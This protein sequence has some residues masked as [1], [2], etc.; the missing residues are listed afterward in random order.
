MTT[1]EELN[2]NKKTARIA[3][4][5]YLIVAVFG[6]FAIIFVLDKVYSPGDAATT[7]ANVLAN[8]SLVR[9]GVV[10]DLIQATVFVFLGMLL[11]QLLKHVNKNAARSMV[12]L[13]AIATTIMC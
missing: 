9:I 2:S 12:I 5:L 10:A 8:S 11:Y 3:G 7:A 6:I 13:V 1:K 4:L